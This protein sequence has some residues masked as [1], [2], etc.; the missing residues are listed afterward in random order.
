MVAPNSTPFAMATCTFAG[1]PAFYGPDADAKRPKT[2]RPSWLG[3]GCLSGSRRVVL[4]GERDGAVRPSCGVEI[5]EANRV[6]VPFKLPLFRRLRSDDGRLG[7]NAWNA[8][9]CFCD[10]RYLIFVFSTAT[11]SEIRCL[12][13]HTN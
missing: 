1:L 3:V 13:S 2:E 10:S 12:G 7:E 8:A 6:G 9:H 4:G 11:S 5:G